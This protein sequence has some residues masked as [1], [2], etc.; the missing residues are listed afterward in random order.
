MTIPLVVLAAGALFV[1]VVVEPFTHWFSHFL[2]HTPS[3]VQ[4]GRAAPGAREMEHQFNWTIAGVGTACVLLGILL[5][6]LLYRNGGPEKVPAGLEPVWAL[7]RNKLYVDEVYDATVVK[8]ATG[9]AV[10]ARAFDGL[11]DGIAR[12]VA[13]VPRFVGRWARPVQ[14]GLVQFYALSMALGLAVFLTF[15]VFRVTR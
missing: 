7:S 10:L 9:L 2:E 8:P 5:A 3:L 4:A 14:N 15:V 11:L 12:L 13:S 1:G 6:F